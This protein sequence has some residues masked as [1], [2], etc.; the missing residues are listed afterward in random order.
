MRETFVLS[1][2]RLKL[3]ARLRDKKIRDTERL[4]LAEGE[5]VVKQLLSALPHPDMLLALLFKDGSSVPPTLASLYPKKQFFLSTKAFEQIAD[6]EEPQNVMA[7]FKQPQSTLSD[8]IDAQHPAHPSLLL[9]LDGVQ[10]AGNVGTLLRTAAWFNASA[11]MSN[12]H[13][14]D[15]FNPKVVRA[16]AGSLFSLPLIRSTDF[17]NDLHTLKQAGFTFYATALSGTPLSSVRVAP[18][19]LVIVGSEAFGI[20]ER[21]MALADETLCI[22][23]NTKAVESLNA[24]VAAGIVLSTISSALK[25]VE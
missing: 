16:S 23:G 10:D 14:A 3:Y 20:S 21:V 24:A 15:F 7:I 12:T 2:A 17:L 22:Q 5:R 1:K 9:A 11:V 4:F 25:L 18:K 8:V 19:S 13:T 6:A